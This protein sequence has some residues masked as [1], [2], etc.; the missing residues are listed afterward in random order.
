MTRTARSRPVPGNAVRMLLDAGALDAMLDLIARAERW[1]HFENYI[2]RS[3]ETGW[4]FAEAWMAAAR[5]GVR[6]R[7]LYDWLGSRGTSRQFWR[8]LRA[9]GIEV[10]SFN[11]PT[12]LDLVANFTRDHRKLA[13]ADGVIAIV[14]GMCV[15]N[16][17]AGDTSRNIRPW[18]D[19][20]VEISGPAAT[21][22]G[23][24]F[25]AMWTEA[26]GQLPV[27]ERAT[28]VPAAGEAA[29]QVIGGRPG[30]GRFFRMLE[31]LAAGSSERLWI[32][33]AYFVAP[34]RLSRV[35]IDAAHEG[36]DVRLLVPSSSDIPIVRNLTR[37]GY[38]NLLR[39]GVRIYEW[40]GPMLHAKAL[41]V[42]GRWARVGSSNLN[43]SSLLGNYELDVFVDD[44]SFA[45]EAERQFRRDIARSAEI[46]HLPP[47]VPAGLQQVLPGPLDRDAPEVASG[48]H[49]RTGRERRRQVVV[50]LRTVAAGARRSFFGPM[51]IGFVFLGVVFFLLPRVSAYASGGVLL[52]L[53]IGAGL[54][55]F[56]RRSQ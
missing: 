23:Q 47:H 9:A 49:H 21:A 20:A 16:E 51:S 14:G 52:W 8:T 48:V 43:A 5:R 32:T 22:L 27:E 55:A 44:R 7:V 25:A 15:G 53:A 1:L 28:D 33:D 37:I 50:A 19:T 24:S 56:R 30:R 38:R 41:V 29:V 39:A 3:D 2:I 12:P 11:R 40:D 36:V 42:D 31:L 54:E 4:R 45:E 26:R 35:F 13:V 17:W 18:R 10:R 34:R 6:V 46:R